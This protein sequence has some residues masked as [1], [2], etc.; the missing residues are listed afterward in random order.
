MTKL[1]Q[2]IHS[3][4]YLALS[5]KVTKIVWTLFY[6]KKKKKKLWKFQF[7]TTYSHQEE[8]IN[9]DTKKKLIESFINSRQI[10]V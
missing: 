7:R 5:N 10:I 2:E 6:I 9:Y 4:T 1:K 3:Y 8:F